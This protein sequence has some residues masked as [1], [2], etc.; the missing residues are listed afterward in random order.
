MPGDRVLNR[1][2]AVTGLSLGILYYYFLRPE[3]LVLGGLYLLFGLFWRKLKAANHRFWKILTRILQSVTSPLLFGAIFFLVLMPI[4]L[5][6]RLWHKKEDRK[7]STFSSV[8]Q[9]IDTA[10]FEVPW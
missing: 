9:S 4:G 6:Y 3:I 10:F 5:L 7:D 2:L 8:D 1:D